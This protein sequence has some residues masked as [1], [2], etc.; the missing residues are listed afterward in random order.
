MLE[1]STKREFN[2]DSEIAFSEM[3][4]PVLKFILSK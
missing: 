2:I 1:L 3:I 4:T